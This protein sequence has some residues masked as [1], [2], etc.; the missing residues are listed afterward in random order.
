MA[1]GKTA[2][3]VINAIKESQGYIAQA[4]GILGVSRSTFYN[5]LKKFSTAQ[6]TLEV[7]RESRHD[8][9]ESKLMQLI[10]KGNVT[11]IIFY[12]KTQC[13]NRG[14]VERQ[15]VTGA[16]GEGLTIVIKPRD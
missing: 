3:Q 11:A 10:N 9:V 6:E 8:H 12:L 1:N 14:Y 16:E 2:E 13:K 5:Y 7:V 4:A 15:E